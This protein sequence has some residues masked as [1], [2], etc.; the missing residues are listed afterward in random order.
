MTTRRAFLQTT[1]AGL[2]VP[3]AL[4]A[5]DNYPNKPITWICPYGTG[6]NGDTRS[7]QVA[8]PMSVIFKQP[9]IVDNKA[10]AGGN[11]G[12]AAI[13]RAK[14]DG[15]TIGTMSVN[16]SNVSFLKRAWFTARGA[17]LPSP[18]V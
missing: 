13:A 10:G 5:Q 1:A 7:R 11:I 8:K 16:G 9:I 17:K 2:V 18:I 14:P 12:T 6:G 15:Y 3:R 4:F